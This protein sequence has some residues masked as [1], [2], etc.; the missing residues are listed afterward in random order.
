MFDLMTPGPQAS[1]RLGPTVSDPA[2]LSR[3]LA[4]ALD[5][6]DYG[7]VLLDASGLVLHLNHHARQWLDHGDVL[8]VLGRQLRACDPRDVALLHDAVHSAATRGL[9]RLLALGRGEARRV[10][11]LVPV[12]PGVAALVLGKSHVCEDLSLQCFARSHALTAAET[13]VLV[14]L[15]LGA[16]PAQI[17]AEQGVKLST[18]RT[19]IGAI[20]EKTGADSINDLLRLVAA[21]PPMVGVLRG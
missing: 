2:P 17:A 18:V 3:L 7:I 16:R 15:G 6:V 1:Q 13:R 19:Q 5:E 9:R 10:A 21:L 14:A 8:Q 11:A 20:R 12:E 4:R